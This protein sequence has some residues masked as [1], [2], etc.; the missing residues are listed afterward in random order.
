MIRQ[1]ALAWAAVL[2]LVATVLIAPLP[3]PLATRFAAPVALA[4]DDSAAGAGEPTDL[5]VVALHCDAAPAAEALTSFFT[6][7]AAPTEC[8]PAVGVAIAVT[9]NGAPVS[10]SPFTTDVSGS[11]TLPVKLGSAVEVRED[12]KSLPA[13]YKPLTQEANS[14]PYANPVQLDSAVAGAAVLFVNVPTAV[15]TELAQDAPAA[16]AGEATDLAV[17]AL[18]CADAPEAEPLTSF[19][20]SGTP[21]SGCTPAAGVSVVVTENEKPLSGSPFTTDAD[22]TLAV[23]VSLGSKVTVKEDP[24]SLPSGYEPITQEANSV[25]Y[26]NPVQLDS[27]T[28]EAAVL[29]VNVPESV[30]ARLNQGTRAI[31]AGGATNLAHAVARDR[32][33]CDPAYPDERTCIAPGRPLAEPC[34]ITDQRNFTVLAPDPRR[35]DADRDGIGCEP[36]SPR[37]G[38]IAR[39]A[40]FNLYSNGGL[41]SAAPVRSGNAAV[42]DR[43]VRTDYGVR[44]SPPEGSRGNVWLVQRDR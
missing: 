17:V 23:R 30:A 29:F 43:R 31:D 24:T 27:A 10:G 13:G 4:Q 18:Q 1:R 21:P 6:D 3:L 12:P 16:E 41:R 33:G 32:T 8:S 36:I 22:G 11:I 37:G 35:L 19:F 15:A 42:A 5:A 2:A 28:A 20:G 14:V 7:G 34:A 26:A 40:G 39:G 9:E 44:S 38:T 25:P